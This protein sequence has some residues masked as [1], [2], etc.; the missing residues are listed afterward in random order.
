M[1][2]LKHNN[3]DF[4]VTLTRTSY[5]FFLISKVH[6]YQKDQL[7]YLASF[8]FISSFHIRVVLCLL[9]ERTQTKQH[10]RISSVSGGFGFG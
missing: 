4:T 8:V 10:L 5:I 6:S 3:R 7:L 1:V 2:Y 9:A